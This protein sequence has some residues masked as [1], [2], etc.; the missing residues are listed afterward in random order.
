M[1]FNISTDIISAKVDLNRLQDEIEASS[2]TPTLSLIR[3]DG[4]DLTI[5]FS[6]TISS[7]ETTTLTALINAHS[8][9]PYPEETAPTQVEIVQEI[10]PPP[11]SSK[12]LGDG[13]KIFART[14]GKEYTLTLGIN[15]LTFEIPYSQVKINEIEIINCEAGDSVD[16]FV[17]DSTTGSYSTIPNYPLN[18]FGF[19]VKCS[20]DFYRRKSNYDADLFLGMQLYVVYNSKSAKA[21]YINYIL[22][23][24]KE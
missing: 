24:V 15:Y 6:A 1:I 5:E 11:F 16:F 12:V 13:K 18:Q 20:K 17:L 3:V 2:I 23:E 22:H 14:H 8:G 9:E 21:A 4:D 19:D 7:E 10:P